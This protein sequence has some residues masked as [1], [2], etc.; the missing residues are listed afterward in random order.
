MIRSVGHPS[1]WKVPSMPGPKPVS[2]EHPQFARG[3]LV[4]LKS[5]SP[6][7]VVEIVAGETGRVIS[8]VWWNA[9]T[10]RPEMG[11]FYP[12]SLKHVPRADTPDRKPNPQADSNLSALA[13]RAIPTD[14]A[15]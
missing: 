11:V 3:D 10:G 13:R 9:I 8:C 2:A 12:D 4:R 1:T 6:H 5:G 14:Q 7:M 15:K